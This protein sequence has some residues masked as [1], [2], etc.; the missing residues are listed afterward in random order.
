MQSVTK[1]VHSKYNRVSMIIVREQDSTN[2][3]TAINKLC[4]GDGSTYNKV[5]AATIDK[6]FEKATK[7]ILGQQANETTGSPYY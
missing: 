1:M 6:D 3:E 7:R 5:T 4:K 2:G